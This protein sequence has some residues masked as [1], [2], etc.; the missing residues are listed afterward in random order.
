MRGQMSD[1]TPFSVVR[2]R[3]DGI[4]LLLDAMDEP[5]LEELIESLLATR[6]VFVTGKGRSGL[7]AECFAMRLMQLG[8]VAHV[9]GEA[10]CPR[11]TT[12]DLLVAVS[13]S[14]TTP[15]TVQLARIARETGAHVVALTAAPES[16]VAAEADRVVVVPVTGDDVKR[17][18][19]YVV[20]P[21]NNT[22]FE[23]ALLLC[24]DGL[25]YTMLERQGIPEE[26]LRDRHANLE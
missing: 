9:P 6:R 19:H 3:L 16:P 17:G 25:V 4:R 24:F 11:I 21:Y 18:F 1:V 22:L 12:G 15:T 20:G 14:G 10:T 13:C 2:R 23:Q 8:M 5:A 7:V 26:R